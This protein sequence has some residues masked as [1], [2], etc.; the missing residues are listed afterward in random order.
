MATILMI[1]DDS[2]LVSSMRTLLEAQGYAFHSAP[3][4]ERGLQVLCEID[5]D[6]VILDLMMN[7]YTEGF[8]VSQVIR[9]PAETS[10]FARFRHVPIVV[11]TSI[12]KT[13][14]YRF[15]RDEASLPVDAFLEKS[16]P[17]ERLLQTITDLLA[18]SA[19]SRDGSAAV[20]AP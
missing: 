1:D 6:L 3:N 5:P 15:G 20:A 2:D 10:P 14:P 17:I 8:R 7:R 12:H 9:D 4:G 19:A 11:F 16:V 18:R 13:T